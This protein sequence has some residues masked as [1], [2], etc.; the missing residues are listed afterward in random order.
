M[1]K[2]HVNS[3]NI[4]PSLFDLTILNKIKKRSPSLDAIQRID[5]L[6]AT[7][8]YCLPLRVIPQPLTLGTA[9]GV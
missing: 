2:T 8:V 9:A 1:L 5:V 7:A 4:E 3:A 6:R